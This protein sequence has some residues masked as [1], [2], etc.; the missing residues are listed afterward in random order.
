MIFVIN[1]VL[2]DILG[3][4]RPKSALSALMTAIC[5]IAP[6]LAYLAMPLRISDSCR[7]VH[8]GASL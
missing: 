4:L 8:S 1:H 6:D 5:A 2:H 7:Q 3:K